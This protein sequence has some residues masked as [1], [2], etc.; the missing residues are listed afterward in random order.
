MFSIHFPKTL[1]ILLGLLLFSTP[2]TYAWSVS[3]VGKVV[4]A[5]EYNDLLG[6]WIERRLGLQASASGDIFFNAD[7][8]L[9]RATTQFDYGS[10]LITRLE[11]T[12]LTAI[13]WSKIAKKK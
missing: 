2:T 6:M 10:Y 9:G 13:K 3:N 1:T 4:I 8:G 7:T 11:S 12:V 5:K